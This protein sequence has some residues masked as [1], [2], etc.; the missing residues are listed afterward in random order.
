MTDENQEET[1]HRREQRFVV[2]LLKYGG[3]WIVALAVYV[4]LAWYCPW[5]EFGTP[6][7]VA[8][9]HGA[10]GLMLWVLHGIGGLDGDP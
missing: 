6:V 8:V 10:F 4:A 3:C 2:H 1:S 5:R 7:A 9:V